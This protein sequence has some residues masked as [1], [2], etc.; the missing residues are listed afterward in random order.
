MAVTRS[1]VARAAGVSPAVV[2][3]VLNGGPRPAST[4]AHTRV[5][6]A[7]N[8]LG[9]RPNAIASALRGGS[10]RTIGFLNP[11]R[12][13]PFFGELA[14]A[15]ELYLNDHG[16]LV[17]GGSTYGNRASEERLLRTFVD[18]QVDGLIISAGTSLAG[19]AP[20]EFEGPILILEDA[21]G[22]S[23]VATEDAVDAGVTVDHLHHHGHD[24]IGCI[25]GPPQFR[26]EAQRLA[27]WR[28][29]QQRTGHPDG[30]E[31]VA[32][33]EQ[34]QRGGDTAARLLLNPHGRPATLHGHRPSALFVGSDVQ[35]IGALSACHDL[36]L[37]V[38][39][40]V[41][42]VSMGGTRAAAYT[43]PTLTTIRQDVEYLARTACSQLLREIR[44]RQV[45][46]SHIRL[47]GN[48]VIGQTC[49]CTL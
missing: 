45:P 34:S 6:E 10:T 31:L 14:E 44:D 21:D 32:F 23:S 7:V 3:Y 30:D 1:D 5:L 37:R 24:L 18:R 35:A 27:G 22:Y 8:R 39:Q 12:S 47:R 19:P 2:S 17:L 29:L 46:Q 38:P 4:R 40:D 26:S 9:Y 41:A 49:G 15:L 42:V 28:Q 11:N 16:Y 20:A 13:N 36:G 25:V 43:I 48:L 33:A